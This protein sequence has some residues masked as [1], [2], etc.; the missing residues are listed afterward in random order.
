MEL[1]IAQLLAGDYWLLLTLF[2][3][4]DLKLFSQFVSGFC[5]PLCF[6]PVNQACPCLASK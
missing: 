3:L 2:R 6:K 1:D 4:T 5:A